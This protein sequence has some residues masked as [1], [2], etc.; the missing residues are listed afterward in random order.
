MP[1]IAVCNLNSAGGIIRT[2]ANTQ[3]RFKGNPLAVIGCPIDSHGSGPHQGARMV[4]GFPGVTIQGIPICI[5]GSVASCGDT[6]DGQALLTV[7]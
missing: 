2:G 3:V 4:T 1:G 6:A 5:A 7:S